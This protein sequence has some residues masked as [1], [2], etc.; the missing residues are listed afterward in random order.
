MSGTLHALIVKEGMYMCV[1]QKS[2][3]IDQLLK[4]EQAPKQP[5]SHTEQ[6]RFILHWNARKLHRKLKCVYFSR[7]YIKNF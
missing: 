1:A 4:S 3:L 5:V 7:R 6:K 2:S